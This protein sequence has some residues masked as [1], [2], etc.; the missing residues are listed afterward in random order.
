M[1][2]LKTN[3]EKLKNKDEYIYE[4]LNEYIYQNRD[5][6]EVYR[7]FKLVTGRDKSQT[8]EVCAG[9]K[10]VRLNSVYNSSREAEKWADK[11][12]N[13]S[14]ITSF[15]MFGMGNGVFFNAIKKQLNV[16]AYIL[17]FEPD[18]ELF[19]FCL[20]S[21]DMRDILSDNRVALYINGINDKEFYKELSGKINW[22][23]LSTQL[24]C[25]HPSYDRL[26]R[27][28]YIK[29][30]FILEQLEKALTANKKTSLKFAKKFTI[31]AIQ[32]LKHIK[33]DMKVMW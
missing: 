16:S 25:C 3:L 19:L 10:D 2:Y 24:V 30:Q 1:E 6:K 28:E 14:E 7:K 21:F 18:I 31:N 29:Y 13:I 17:F 4:K 5:I 23:M 32:N 27:E 22:A 9:E 20:E 26:Y 15:I 12:K 33:N 11:Y 8:V